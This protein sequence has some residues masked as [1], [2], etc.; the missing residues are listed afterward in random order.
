[1]RHDGT[2]MRVTR[3][4]ILEGAAALGATTLLGGTRA[5]A[6]PAD[7]LIEKTIPATGERVPPIGIGTNRYGVGGNAAE[8]APLRATL[9]VFAELGGK[10]IDTAA[11]YGSSEAVIGDLVAELA[12]RDKLFLATKTDLTSKLAGPA[13][14]QQSFER[15]RTP[16]LDLVQVHNLVNVAN[17]LAVLRDAKAAGR[18]RY[19][20]V[21]ISTQNQYADL[22]RAMR[23]EQIDFVQVNYSLEDRSA[24]DRLLPLAAQRGFAVLVNLP[25]GRGSA[26][27]R[28]GTRALPD[29]AAEFDCASWGQF[30][31]KY[32][33]S[34][35]AVTCAIPGTRREEHVRDNFAAARGRLPDEALRRRQEQLFDSL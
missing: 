26:F 19:V 32:I 9:K 1:M 34:H 14:L 31:L 17:E 23:A 13:A 6:Q 21:T 33:V 3:R 8:R 5:L 27:D 30:F 22:E 15:L 4:S 2:C 11:V 7:G 29:W 12:L 24:G 35:P 18:V 20:G 28:V 25:F 10:V 16:T